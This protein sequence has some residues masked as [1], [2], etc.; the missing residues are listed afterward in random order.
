MRSPWPSLRH[1]PSLV[2]SSVSVVTHIQHSPGA[3]RRS[4]LRCATRS[5][6]SFP[7]CYERSGCSRPK[8]ETTVSR[9]W[10]SKEIARLRR[11]RELGAAELARLLGHSV[12]SV[13]MAA[14]RQRITLRRPGERGG[15]LLGQARKACLPTDQR[16]WASLTPCSSPGL[17]PR[18]TGPY[19]PIAGAGLSRSPRPGSV[20]SA[21]LVSS[22]DSP[23][24]VATSSTLLV[25]WWTC[26]ST[27]TAP[28][29]LP[30]MW[31]AR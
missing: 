26:S 25:R 29:S 30:R 16:E 14:Y 7:S 20:A 24:I 2:R 31:I 3:A 18:A 28:R 6:G 17:R 5:I 4:A 23:A 11:D 12:H 13:K 19:V 1:A 9:P 27:F 22:I 10:T 8:C 15:H 21:P